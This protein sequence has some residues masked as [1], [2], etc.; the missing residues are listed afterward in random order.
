MAKLPLSTLLAADL[1]ENWTYG[2]IVAPTGEEVGLGHQYGYNYQS[3]Q[4]NLAQ[5]AA[6]AINEAF[7]DVADYVAAPTPGKSQ[8]LTTKGTDKALISL[9]GRT[10][11]EKAEPAAEVS[12]DNLATLTGVHNPTITAAS[13]DNTQSNTQTVKGTLYNLPNGVC[14]EYDG[15]SGKLT[16]RVGRLVLDGSEDEGWFA[17]TY[18]W[19]TQNIIPAAPPK[20]TSGH[21]THFQA[22]SGNSSSLVGKNQLGIATSNQQIS[23]GKATFASLEALKTYLASQSTAGTPVTVLYELAEP[24]TTYEQHDLTCYEGQTII[25]C[26]N[27]VLQ[28][29]DMAV[30]MADGRKVAYAARADVAGNAYQLGGIPASEYL[31][32]TYGAWDSTFSCDGCTVTVNYAEYEKIG[33][34]VYIYAKAVLTPISGDTNYLRIRGLPYPHANGKNFYAGIDFF[35]SFNIEA[36]GVC[37]SISNQT[38]WIQRNMWN[39]TTTSTTNLRANEIHNTLTLTISGTYLTD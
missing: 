30:T 26:D 20:S 39:G 24:V 7:A 17:A 13:A 31:S 1:P 34:Q 11:V 22:V 6:N 23:I 29:G 16:R 14:D 18:V 35:Q 15:V 28:D 10:Q 12:P 9:K 37:G 4:I 2:Q 36:V 25:S 33:K 32:V 38:I 19:S 21:C 5:T 3:E 27:P 8:A